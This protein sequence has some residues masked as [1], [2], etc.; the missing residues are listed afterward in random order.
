MLVFKRDCKAA[1]FWRAAAPSE[2]VCLLVRLTETAP[3][4]NRRHANNHGTRGTAL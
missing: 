1:I 2:D 4:H 3:R